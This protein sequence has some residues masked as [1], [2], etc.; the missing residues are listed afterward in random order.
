M[1]N[2]PLSNSARISVGE[3]RVKI[4]SFILPGLSMRRHSKTEADLILVC[5]EQKKVLRHNPEVL[6]LIN[7]PRPKAP[8]PE[9]QDGRGV[10]EDV[11]PPHEHP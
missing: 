7:P 5:G 11:A 6:S 8:S 4:R 1:G 10:L 9:A 3:R 2:N